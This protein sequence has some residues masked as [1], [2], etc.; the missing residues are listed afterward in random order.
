MATVLFT[1]ELGGGLG[2]LATMAPVVRWLRERG[3]CVVAALRD[4]SR[5]R[6]VLGTEIDLYQAPVRTRP[7][8]EWIDPPR[9]FAHI[10]HNSGFNDPAELHA[11]TEAWGNLYRCIRPDLIMFDH[12]PTAL[13]AA[14]GLSARKA[15]LG[16]GFFCPPDVYPLPDLRPWMPA[17]PERL[18]REEDR[19]CGN[20]NRVLASLGRPQLERLAHLYR[21]VE[22]TFLTTFRDLDAYGPRDKVHYWGAWPN[23]EGT[24][25]SWPDVAGKRVFG[26]LKAFPAL[27]H[28]LEALRGAAT[29]TIIYGDGISED[30]QQRYAC[31]S[32]RFEREPLNLTEVGRQCDLAILNGTHGATVAILLAGKPVLELPLYL[33]QA[34]TSLKVA[35]LG[36]GI[37]VSIAEAHR[38]A[39]ALSTMLGS[40]AYAAAARC[41]AQRYASDC[42]E[43]TGDLLE[44]CGTLLN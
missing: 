40:D 23:S 31:R 36:A 26:Y 32:L 7:A 28:L 41:F 17:D 37:T 10:L 42:A 4:L 3:H 14:R 18:R 20:A 33:E 27:P 2:H 44:R 43:Q 12:S 11:L 25:P 15:L 35:Q 34:L 1:W 13:L 16:P 19:V 24:S 21:D 38:L 9:T 6:Q 22:E 5:A 39:P 30:I 8:G 29:P